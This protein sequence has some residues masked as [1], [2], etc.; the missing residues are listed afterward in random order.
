MPMFSGNEWLMLLA[1]L[2]G[3]TLVWGLVSA[4]LFHGAIA[5]FNWLCQAHNQMPTPGFGRALLVGIVYTGLLIV[6]QFALQMLLGLVMVAGMR[7]VVAPPGGPGG[8]APMIAPLV[9]MFGVVVFA[10]MIVGH[11]SLSWLLK[12]LLSTAFI[13]CRFGPASLIALLWA[14]F[15]AVLGV[16]IWLAVSLGMV[17]ILMRQ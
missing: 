8:G 3:G 15:E 13:P 10:L 11:L 5:A 4:A 9:G 1:F 17:L 12:A 14:A 2:G 16:A 6:G 7:G